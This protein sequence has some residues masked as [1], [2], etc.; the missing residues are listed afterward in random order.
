MRRAFAKPCVRRLLGAPG[1]R[2]FR[3]GRRKGRI[4]V[5]FFSFPDSKNA[6]NGPHHPPVHPASYLPERRINATSLFTT[7]SRQTE[8]SFLFVPMGQTGRRETDSESTNGNSPMRG[9]TPLRVSQEKF[10]CKRREPPFRPDK[11]FSQIEGCKSFHDPEKELHRPKKQDETGG[12]GEG[13]LHSGTRLSDQVQGSKAPNE[14][15]APFIA[16]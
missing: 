9:V 13:L 12:G 15:L 8:L 4:A 14:N 2:R 16:E 11:T 1:R 6:K 5:F 3:W 10:A 7:S